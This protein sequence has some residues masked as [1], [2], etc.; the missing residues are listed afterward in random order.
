MGFRLIQPITEGPTF[1]INMRLASW[2]HAEFCPGLVMIWGLPR[3]AAVALPISF[4][5]FGLGAARRGT[6]PPLF[7]TV[8]HGVAFCLDLRFRPT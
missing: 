5:H 4:V 2:M 7:M 3:Q 6:E 8:E 1:C